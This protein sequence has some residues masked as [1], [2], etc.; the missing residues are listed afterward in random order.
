MVRACQSPVIHNA[1]NIV[2][3][4]RG[5]GT[6]SFRRFVF[7]VF[8]N[9]E[10]LPRRE[11]LTRAVR[12]GV[13]RALRY[14][15][16]NHRVRGHK[17]RFEQ[18]NKSSLICRSLTNRSPRHNANNENGGLD[19]RRKVKHLTPRTGR[20]WQQLVLFFLAH[21]LLC[22]C[23]PRIR[24]RVLGEAG[25]EDSYLRWNMPQPTNSFL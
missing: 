20:H 12:G 17:R 21:K 3:P 10:I 4:P 23:C 22:S 25:P 9:G 18:R 5:E 2:V 11:Y 19:L 15:R 7:S 14:G 6:F 13:W 8:Y 16:E 1:C 24:A